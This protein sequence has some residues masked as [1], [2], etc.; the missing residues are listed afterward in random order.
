MKKSLMIAA[1][2]AVIALTLSACSSDSNTTDDTTTISYAY[3]GNN[4]ES[5]TLTSMVEAFEAENDDIDVEINWIQSDYEQRL[6]TSIAGGQQP[7]VAQISNHV[8]PGFANAFAIRE[9]DSSAYHLD[10]FVTSMTVNGEVRATPFAAKPKVMAINTAVFADAGIDVPSPETVLTVDE[11]IELGKSLTSGSGSDKVF[12]SSRLY[13]M[14]WL[15]TNGGGTYTAEGTCGLDD[16]IAATAAESMIEA[17]AADGWTPTQA[18]AEGQDMFQ[19]LSIGRIGMRIDMGPWD[20]PNL[21]AANDPQIQVMRLP[22]AGEPMEVT[23]LGISA[24]ASE[25]EQAAAERFVD[26]M[27]TSTVAQDLL[28]TVEASLG[29]PVIAESLE[30]FTDVAPDL[31]LAAYIEAMNASVIEPGQVNDQQIRSA[32]TE[33]LINRTALGVGNEDPAV[34][35]AEFNETCQSMLDAG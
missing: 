19:W 11:F 4:L 7:T 17:Q 14:N 24:S 6:Q 9:I 29:V 27:S 8:L 2:A 23:G 33:E 28:T 21:I 1:S 25:E 34:V 31:N 30:A 12:G 18:D 10:A 32:L 15:V 35:L 13:Y 5:A 26:F 3:W 22:G 16:P 20:I